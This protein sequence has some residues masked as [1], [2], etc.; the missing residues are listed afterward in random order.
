[1][2]EERV[3]PDDL[4]RPPPRTRSEPHIT[5]WDLNLRKDVLIYGHRHWIYECDQFTKDFLAAQGVL[6]DPP[7]P[8]PEDRF[9]EHRKKVGPT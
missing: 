8:L 3:A 9:E 1:M 7:E 4:P 5:F 2:P 6:V